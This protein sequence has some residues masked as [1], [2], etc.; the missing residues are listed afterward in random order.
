VLYNLTNVNVTE[1]LREIATIKVL[2]FYDNEVST[3]V[4]RENFL[5]TIIGMTLGLL[6][7]IFLHRFIIVTSEIDYVMFGRNIKPLSYLYS[8]I[9]TIVFSGIVNF[10]MYFKL[11]KIGMVESLKSV[12]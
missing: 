6:M 8:A 12:D 5:L 7:G 3:Y 1:R 11:K 4:Y 9:L 2:G 10:V